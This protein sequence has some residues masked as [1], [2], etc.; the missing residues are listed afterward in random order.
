MKPKNAY[1]IITYAAL[2]CTAARGDT[3]SEHEAIGYKNA[4][5]ADRI[6]RFSQDLANGKTQIAWDAKT[7]YLPSLMAAL[8]VPA[9]SQTL[10][11]SK[12]SFQ[13]IHISPKAPRALYFNDDVYVGFVQGADLLELSAIDPVLGAIFYVMDNRQRKGRGPVPHR[14]HDECLQCHES[15]LTN[16]VPG[17]FIRSVFPSPSGD[18]ILSEGTYRTTTS[19]PIEERWGG[20][21]VTGTHGR[22]RHMGNAT[23]PDGKP[24]ESLNRDRGANLTSLSPFVDTRPYLRSTSDIVALLILEHQTQVHTLI[25]KA[26]YLTRIAMVENRAINQ[27]LGEPI[28]QLRD[29]TSRRID[30]AVEPLLK[31]MLFSGEPKL[32]DPLHGDPTF[33]RDF[34]SRGPRDAKGRSLRKLDLQHRLFTYPLSYLIDSA[35]FAALPPRASAR[36][37]ERLRLVLAG[38]DHDPDLQHL[39]AVDRANLGD[40]IRLRP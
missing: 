34:E 28:E 9:S 36:F 14:V 22:A 35:A 2:I 13:R 33:V 19:S 12:T 26:G 25:T 10:V 15:G 32:V 23:L 27:A 24:R 1:A 8:G 20:W 16:E 17:L 4:V 5:A 6:A 37:F 7:G 21:Y 29:S 18:P 30:A 38:R 3:L 39:S 40:I 11:F 31:A